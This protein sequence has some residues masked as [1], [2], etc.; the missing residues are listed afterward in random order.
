MTLVFFI[1]DRCSVLKNRRSPTPEDGAVAP[2]QV[3]CLTMPHTCMLCQDPL[4]RLFSG[5]SSSCRRAA[6]AF[7]FATPSLLR[8]TP[9][10]HPVGVSCSTVIWLGC[11]HATYLARAAP[12][13]HSA[14]PSFLAN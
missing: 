9:P 5:A 12:A 13:M 4:L 14:A 1:K 6:L 2:A 11:C 7:M 10:G 8:N 3:A